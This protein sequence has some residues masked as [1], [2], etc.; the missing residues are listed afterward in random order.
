MHRYCQRRIPWTF[1]FPLILVSLACLVGCQ[2]RREGSPTG[3]DTAATPEAAVL[4]LMAAWRS[5]GAMPMP[6]AQ[7]ATS[8][9]TGTVVQSLGTIKFQDLSGGLHI[10]Q[11][12]GKKFL[13]PEL[14]EVYTTYEF[15]QDPALVGTRADITFVMTLQEGVWRL[16]DLVFTKL[17][18]VIVVGGLGVQGY[19][20]DTS[21]TPAKPI[22]NAAAA[23]YLGE[24]LI[25]STLTDVNGFYSLTASAPGT[26][27]L[28]V[29]KDGYEFLTVPNLYLY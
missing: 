29:T 2:D 18:P 1:L 6:L 10:F 13:S 24:T 8:T 15:T 7:L 19:I 14:A 27:T 25:D 26:Y 5:E 4:A 20:R 16:D 28:T 21:V 9:A 17:P 23:L 12:I 22:E 3:A 11:V